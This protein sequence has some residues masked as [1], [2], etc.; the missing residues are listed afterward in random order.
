VE[1]FFIMIILPAD[2]PEALAATDVVHG[3]HYATPSLGR[4]SRCVPMHTT[5]LCTVLLLN[6]AFSVPTT[7]SRHHW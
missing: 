4:R 3:V 5:R 7:D 2:W 1:C 6:T